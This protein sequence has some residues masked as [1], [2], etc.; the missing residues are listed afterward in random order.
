MTEPTRNSN[1]VEDLP[2]LLEEID[3]ILRDGDNHSR[4]DGVLNRLTTYNSLTDVERKIVQNFEN[5]LTLRGL[6]PPDEYLTDVDRESS[7][8]DGGKAGCVY[9]GEWKEKRVVVKK[10]VPSPTPENIEGPFKEKLIQRMEPFAAFCRELV[11]WKIVSTFNCVWPVLGY[12][13]WLDQNEMTVVF[14]LVSPRAEGNLKLSYDERQSLE[15]N[16]F[17]SYFRDAATGLQSLH[18]HGVIHGDIHPKNLLQ[19]DGNCYLVDFGMSKILDPTS[20]FSF[21]PAVVTA[22]RVP[23]LNDGSVSR[24]NQ[25]TDIFMLGST[26][27]EI[28][29]GDILDIA[30]GH[31]ARPER[32]DGK[33]WEDLWNLVLHCMSK[34]PTDRPTALDLVEKLKA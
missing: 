7:S 15:P 10:F 18:K 29:T 8:F 2:G 13:M 30:T 17:A 16:K 33:E 6:L 26:M 11:L 31:P 1:F 14:A 3:K 34:E 25:R 20:S 4:I 27:Y 28:L 12:T 22:Q 19:N 24:R 23:E 21:A 9:K 5:A 32:C